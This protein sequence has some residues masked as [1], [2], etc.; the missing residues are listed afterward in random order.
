MGNEGQMMDDNEKQTTSNKIKTYRDLDAWKEAH[1][2]TLAIYKITRDFPD[3]EMFGL[4]SQIR[5]A[6]VSAT[7]NIAEG[8]A[9]ESYRE[10]VH[11][12]SIAR[13]S[14]IEIDNQLLTAKDVGYL[15]EPVYKKSE[16]QKQKALR[17]TNGLL[18]S[19]KRIANEQQSH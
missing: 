11:F 15:G 18:A 10:K 14:L 13:G 9:R 2:L 19:T 17:I 12:Y 16:N 1:K 3:E 5:R 6:A 4:T 8:F 7:S